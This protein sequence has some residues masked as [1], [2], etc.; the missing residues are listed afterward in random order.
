MST[1]ET[2]DEDG[3]K[4]GSQWRLDVRNVGGIDGASVT[5]DPGVTVVAGENASNKSSLLGSLGGV[6]GGPHP[7]LRG[8][9]G[10]GSVTL[11]A[12]GERYELDLRRRDGETVV[13]DATP[14]APASTLVDLFVVLGE[15]N[16]IRRA[17]VD[18]GDLHD[19]LMRPVDTEAIDAEIERLRE[20]RDGIDGRVASL[21]DSVDDL[22]ELE[23]RAR[24][25]ADE[26]DD[27]VA[28]L[29]EKRAAL[30]GTDYRGAAA[31]TRAVL[32][33]LETA[34]EER[35]RL[36]ERRET[37][38]RA[39]ESLRDD[40]EAVEERLAESTPEGVE[41]VEARLEAV[42]DDL[43]RLRDRTGRLDE[44]INA[45]SPIVEMN[46]EFLAE[47]RLP[48][49]FDAA[50]ALDDLRP[51]AGSV[52]CWT[53]GQ[54]V[55]RAEI[56]AQ[57]EAVEAILGEKRAERATVVGRIE[58]LQSERAALRARRDERADLVERRRRLERDVEE[59]E[60]TLADLEE[61]LD[62]VRDRIASLEAD[63]D[64]TDA[65][66]AVVERHREVSELE[67]ERGRLERE[68]AEVEER[69]EAAEEAKAERESLREERDAVTDRLAACRERV[70]RIER[71]TVETV[72]ECLERVLDRLSYRALERVWVERREEE[73]GTV[74]DLQVVRTADDG[75]VYRAPVATLSKSEREVVGL[76][77]ALAGYLVYDVA[78]TV[79]AVVVD[80]IEMLDA[81]RIQGLL[82][83]FSDH[84]RYVVG[85]ALPEE[86]ERLRERFETVALAS[87]AT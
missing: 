39:V 53:C 68:L 25:L 84:A 74:F 6:L 63:L 1:D 64:A 72:N 7:P 14:Y 18:G 69:I 43:R 85:A 33:D 29:D 30:E 62:D 87:S 15:E 32:D 77:I 16:P 83:V 60:R 70:E 3:R 75:G 8:G 54:P 12:D 76:V 82:D 40:L 4:G 20:R 81:E 13:V 10:A 9:C 66:D 48:E 52:T 59:R 56:E 5:L 86:A 55:E 35:E 73:P 34:R 61:R 67:Y 11:D 58:D 71:E 44:T 49:A 47:A 80:A 27:V 50:D 37:K 21:D 28:R 42:E 46:Q 19:L 17:V 45:L 22:P 41:S 79:P 26:R 38:R 24:R 36:R 51:D 78:E 65:A 2:T 23:V 31:A 57:V